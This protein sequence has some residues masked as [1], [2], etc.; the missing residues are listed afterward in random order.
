MYCDLTLLPNLVS[1]FFWEMAVSH[2]PVS[3]GNVLC[4]AFVDLKGS[5]LIG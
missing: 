2:K 3:P 5:P 1:S 4:F